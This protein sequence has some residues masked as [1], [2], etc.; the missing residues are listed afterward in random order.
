MASYGN[1]WG[2]NIV[3]TVG[4]ASSAILTPDGKLETMPAWNLGT[5]VAINISPV[6]VANINTGW[7]GLNPSE[8]RSEDKIKLGGSGHVNLIWSPYKSVNAGV[9]FMTLYRENGNGESGVGTRLQMMI[10][11]LF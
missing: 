8:F 9:E 7:F 10:K 5:G 4:T 6:L 1:G 2:S 11:Y 3:A